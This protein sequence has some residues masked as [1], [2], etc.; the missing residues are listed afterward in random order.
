MASVNTQER[1]RK[2]EVELE[3]LKRLAVGQPSFGADE[4]NWAKIATAAKQIRKKNYRT[5]Y[6]SK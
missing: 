1:I 3:A 4:K 2:V 6:G 5:I